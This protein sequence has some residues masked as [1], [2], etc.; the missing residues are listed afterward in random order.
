MA[1]SSSGLEGGHPHAIEFLTGEAG[2]AAPVVIPLRI[3]TNVREGMMTWRPCPTWF[4]LCAIVAGGGLSPPVTAAE[5]VM[6]FDIPAEDLGSALRDFSR[7]SNQEILF[8]SDVVK[9]KSTRGIHGS[10]PPDAALA[11]LLA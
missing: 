2:I 8:S 6:T 1:R 7:Q 10:L 4:L 9:G 11:Q 5:P 3:D